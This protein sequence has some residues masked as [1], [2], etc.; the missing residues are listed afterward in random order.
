MAKPPTSVRSIRLTDEAWEWLSAAAADRGVKVNAFVA[1]LVNSAR[2]GVTP[3]PAPPRPAPPKLA[4]AT[5]AP[6]R[7]ERRDTY[8]DWM[9][10]R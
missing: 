5:P 3:A 1:L 9:R 6:S 2:S 8:P 4:P 7:Y 10:K